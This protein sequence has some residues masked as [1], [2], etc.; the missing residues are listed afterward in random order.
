MGDPNNKTNIPGDQSGS[1]D[2][3]TQ[4]M[5]IGGEGTPNSLGDRTGRVVEGGRTGEKPNAA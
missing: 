1:S 3:E 2:D 4:E 5:K